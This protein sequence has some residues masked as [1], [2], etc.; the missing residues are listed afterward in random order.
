MNFKRNKKYVARNTIV[1]KM[2]AKGKKARG[3]KQET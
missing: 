3:K 2:V 1:D